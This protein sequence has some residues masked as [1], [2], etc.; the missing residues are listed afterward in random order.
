M[1]KSFDLKRE[2]RAN[3]VLWNAPRQRRR[4]N[5]VSNDGDDVARELGLGNMPRVPPL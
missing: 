4:Q 5:F 3:L 2:S 1:L